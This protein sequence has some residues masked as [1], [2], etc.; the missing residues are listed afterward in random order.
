VQIGGAS[1]T[2]TAN[3][4]FLINTN[5]TATQLQ[6]TATG[7]GT[8][9]QPLPTLV[10]TPQLNDIGDVFVTAD[11][12]TAIASGTVVRAADLTPVANATVRL[13]GQVK[14]TGASGTFQFTGLPVGLGSTT[15]PVGLV[16]A[17]Q[18]EN[19]PII[20]EFPLGASTGTPPAVNDLGQIQM[21]PLVGSIPGGPS[22]IRG[23][24]DTPALADDSGTVVNLR[25]KSDNSLILTTTTNASGAYGFFVI[26]GNYVVETVRTGFQTATADAT[27]TSPDT[28]VVK[29][30]T[31]VVT[32]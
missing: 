2:T 1:F 22:N 23:T 24:V 26:A 14:I 13:N 4:T 6:V 16:T 20:L 18:L 3:G 21:V 17:D 25:L 7:A 30:F 9:T 19:K 28:V 31:L 27:L 32:P 12:Y 10:A 15:D 5:T 29:N 8:L 11:G